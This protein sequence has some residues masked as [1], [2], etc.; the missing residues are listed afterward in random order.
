MDYSNKTRE[1]LILICKENNIKRYSGKKKD[2]I[3]KLL[4]KVSEKNEIIEEHPVTTDKLKFIDLFCGIG[5]FHQALKNM[6]GECVYACD[7]DDDCRIIY[8]KNYGIKPKSDITKIKIDEISSFDVLCGGF[9]CFIEGTKVLTY[10][11]Y[12]N[13]EDVLLYDKLLTHTGE[14]QN[15]LNLQQKL[16]NGDLYEIDIKYHSNTINCTSEHP[17]YIRERKREWDSK[18]NIY[19]YTFD[20]PIW[21]KANELTENDYFGM[22]IN[23]KNIIPEFTFEKEVIKLDKSKEWY[24]M[25]YMLGKTKE[26][27]TI[28]DKK[29]IYIFGKYA[30]EKIIPEWVQDAPKEFIQEFINGY[31]NS[32]SILDILPS[33]NKL[34]LGIHRLNLK[35]NMGASLIEDNYAWFEPLKITKKN[36]VNTFVYNFE[37]ENDN[38]YIVENTIV[39]NCQP[40]SKAGFQKG[41]EDGRGNLFFNICDI[42]KKHMPK[43]LL[44]E[45]VRNLAS[46]DDGNTWKVIYENIDKL[47]YYTYEM[48]VILNAL[49]FNIPQNR[50]RVIIMCKRKDLGELQTLPVIPKNPKQNLT[51]YIN[52]FLCDKKDTEKYTID[53][54]LK[55]VEFVWNI[56]IKLLI[57]KNIDIPKFPIWTDWWDNIFEEDDKFYIKYKSWIDKNREFYNNNKIIL[58]EWLITSRTNKNWFGAVRKF[59][60]QAGDLMK[61]DSMNTVLWS[62]RGSGIR[63]KRC[64]YI[65]TLVA[66]AMIPVYGPESRKLSPRELLRLQSFPDTFQYNEKK[67]YKQVGNSV[68]VKMIECCARFLIF[69]EKLL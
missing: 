46:H 40:F 50:E 18:L 48:P 36:L 55:D 25:G 7:I 37:V 41:F 62:A 1:E 3:I 27:F 67:I 56:F 23:N 51:T 17:F 43:Y 13:I 60:W 8:E 66:M 44:L 16:Y 26:I 59:E 6:N 61:D 5:G 2:D 33:Y 9:P 14:F 31:I 32:N 12:K 11:G 57:E 49:H 21:K 52:E 20:K 65:P 28:F 53:G 38:S 35:L 30:S 19:I 47:G 39:H 15:I 24:M 64:N 29:I 4:S 54:K 10:N 42:I 22:I 68:N 45:N 63:V 58:E 34:T 69:N